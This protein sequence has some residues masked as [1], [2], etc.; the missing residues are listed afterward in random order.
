MKTKI[1]PEHH[2][3]LA[4]ASSSF[5]DLIPLDLL[6]SVGFS[7]ALNTIKNPNSATAK[8][9]KQ[10]IVNFVNTVQRTRPEWFQ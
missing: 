1:A 9:I 7:A 3:A 2:A 5:L 6:L 10:V 8:K 4:T